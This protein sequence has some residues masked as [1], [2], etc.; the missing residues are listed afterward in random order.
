M[1]PRE[2]PGRPRRDGAAEI[3]LALADPRQL[4]RDAAVMPLGGD[5][6]DPEAASFIAAEAR[7][8][9]SRA[10]LRVKVLLPA[11]SAAGP[12]AARIAPSIASHFGRQAEAAS[13]EAGELFRDGRL[14]LVIG[15]TVLMACLLG[16]YAI[17]GLA[18]SGPAQRILQES[19][20]ILGWVSLWRPA[21]TFIYGWAPILTHMFA[22][23]CQEHG[24]EH[25]FTRINHPWTNGQVQRMNRAI[26][27]ATVKRF[28]YDSHEQL[29]RHLQDF[30]A[31][32]NFASRLKRLRG[33]TPYEFICK[34]WSAKHGLQNMGRRATTL[35]G[36]CAPPNPGTKHLVVATLPL[37]IIGVVFALLAFRQPLGFVPI[38]GILAL[39]GMIAKN[40]VILIVQIE[41]ERGSGRALRGVV[42]G[43]AASRFRPMM[44]TAASTVLGMVPIA[45]TVFWGP[46][47]F[48]IMGGL[49]VAT[50]LTLVFLPVPYVTAFGRAEPR[51]TPG[52]AMP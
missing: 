38:L 46:M 2:R 17:A 44:L 52:L 40:A 31:A 24:I 15:L 45:L 35:Q 7:R 43:A 37:G 42:V 12:D 41:A 13:E 9:P 29:R 27:D 3:E 47:A 33:L 36:K 6:L 11:A 10:M 18:P 22:M 19:L 51:A 8:H 30:V 50:L 48:A 20:V 32:Y 34:T 1:I 23:R 5:P 25:R 16:A 49:L 28:H 4:L 39:L 14:T 26:K 21:E